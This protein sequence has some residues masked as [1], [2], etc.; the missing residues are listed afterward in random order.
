M[1]SQDF[2]LYQSLLQQN[3]GLTIGPDK[4]Y[5][6]E[7]RLT[8]IAKKW[9]F[10]SLE[11][12]SQHLHKT[13][14]AALITQIV[15]AMATNETLFFRDLKPF[16]LF[17]EVVLPHMTENRRAGQPIRIW[18][19]A[20]ST[21]QEPYSIAMVLKDNEDKL[22]GRK[23]EILATDISNQALEKARAAQ[24]TQ[25]EVQRGMSVQYLMKYFTQDGDKWRL[26]DEIRNMVKFQYFNLLSD[27]S[28]LGTFDVI[29]CRNVLIYF[30][31]VTKTSV[32][33]KLARCMATD[34]FLFL[35]GA[36]TVLGLT[37]KFKPVSDKRGIYVHNNAQ[38]PAVEEANKVLERND[39]Q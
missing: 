21:G 4:T 35:G 14:D 1:K 11:E 17:E 26:K 15:E 36:E 39:K 18:C 32:L 8:P 22:K 7:S 31:E 30:D 20:A 13:R 12:M 27:M 23:C 2:E 9:G 28:R 6:I 24:Y 29:F 37:D 19:T 25:F 34:G 16:K 5:L 3:S 10:A 38:A 33:E